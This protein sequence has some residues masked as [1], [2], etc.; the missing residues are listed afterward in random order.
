MNIYKTVV[1]QS[2]SDTEGKSALGMFSKYKPNYIFAYT[3]IFTHAVKF[4]LQPNIY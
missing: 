4:K 3:S 1:I 2:L